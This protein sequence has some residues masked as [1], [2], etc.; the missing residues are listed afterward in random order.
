MIGSSDEA[1]KVRTQK[2][3]LSELLRLWPLEICNLEQARCPDGK[4]DRHT[5]A[6]TLTANV[7][8]KLRDSPQVG[9]T[10]LGDN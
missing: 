7:T 6:K 2:Q 4:S 3:Q 5:H 1:V 10:N 9:S 8:A